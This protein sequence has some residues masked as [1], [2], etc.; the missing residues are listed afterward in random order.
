M[1]YL[2]IFFEMLR[3]VWYSELNAKK[4]GVE[5]FFHS[6]FN[7]FVQVSLLF[8]FCNQF[9]SKISYSSILEFIDISKASDKLN[10]KK[11]FVLKSST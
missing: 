6:N 8:Y 11:L 1:P 4:L 5:H 2:F 3:N 10:A 9:N 7:V